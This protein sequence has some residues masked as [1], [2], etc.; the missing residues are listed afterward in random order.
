[1]PKTIVMCPPTHF[2]VEYELSTNE[3]MDKSVRPDKELA[4]S[5]WQALYDACLR[6]GLKVLLMKPEMGLPD[7][8]FAANAG[9]PWKKKFILSRL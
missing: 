9:L 5:Q 7:L 1:M 4:Q 3:W 2:D 6:A 8:T